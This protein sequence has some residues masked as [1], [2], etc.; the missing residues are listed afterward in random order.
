LLPPPQGVWF[1]QKLVLVF[2]GCGGG[3]IF[4]VVCSAKHR[5]LPRQ[6]RA[7]DRNGVHRIIRLCEGGTIEAIS[8]QS[9]NTDCF[10]AKGGR[11]IA[12]TTT[13]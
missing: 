3:V 5:L 1:I 12:M 11:L 9:P 6:R 13:E 7:L 2:L 8:P 10:P 4:L